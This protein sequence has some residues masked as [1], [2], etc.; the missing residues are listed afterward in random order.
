MW[1]LLWEDEV[2]ECMNE[3]KRGREKGARVEEKSRNQ[4]I[5]DANE[6]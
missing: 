2:G 5:D 3:S 6:K 4:E 1:G